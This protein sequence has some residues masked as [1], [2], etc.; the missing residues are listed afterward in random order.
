MHCAGVIDYAL[1]L[2]I[3]KKSTVQASPATFIKEEYQQILNYAAMCPNTFMRFYASNM[4]L[5]VDSNVA[6]L[7]I[8][9]LG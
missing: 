7:A 5:I 6:C 4:V 2:G 9:K 8:P 1:L 3:N